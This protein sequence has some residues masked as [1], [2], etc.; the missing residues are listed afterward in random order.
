MILL[1]TSW[2][3]LLLWWWP[4]LPSLLQA[5]HMTSA[6]GG[7]GSSE[8]CPIGSPLF[9]LSLHTCL[10][11][12][13]SSFGSMQS[14]A[15][16]LKLLSWQVTHHHS[17]QE[18]ERKVRSCNKNLPSR[19]HNQRSLHS[20]SI[21]STFSHSVITGLMHGGVQHLHGPITFQNPTSEHMRHCRCF[22]SVTL[23]GL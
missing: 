2:P 7:S 5:P 16:Y 22:R 6:W 19:I 17:S 13:C 21:G 18:T 3:R 9:V 8:Q 4:S 11:V 15:C 12:F 10:S 23:R 14:V 1:G 20:G